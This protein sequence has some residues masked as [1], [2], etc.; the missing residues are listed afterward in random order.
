[1]ESGQ[2]IIDSV[3][4]FKKWRGHTCLGEAVC[5]THVALSWCKTKLHGGDWKTP[6]L[7]GW[8]SGFG[9]GM[10]VGITENFIVFF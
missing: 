7:L 2:S 1:M 5:S 4:V 10:V 3:F 8:M 6:S 9:V